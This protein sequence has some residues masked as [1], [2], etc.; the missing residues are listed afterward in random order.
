[1]NPMSLSLNLAPSRT[2]I[3]KQCL[4]AYLVSPQILVF[5]LHVHKL[6]IHKLLAQYMLSP[7]NF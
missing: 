1:M 3:L 7:Q 6:F 2:T 5:E 4:V